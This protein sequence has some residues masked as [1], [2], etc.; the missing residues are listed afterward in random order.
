MPVVFHVIISD[1]WDEMDPEKY[2]VFIRFGPASLGTFDPPEDKHEMKF[3]RYTWIF[4]E[5]I[6]TGLHSAYP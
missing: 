1:L 2:P 4:K 6:I 5:I 3:V